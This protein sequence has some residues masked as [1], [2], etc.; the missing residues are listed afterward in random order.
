MAD[1]RYWWSLCD[2]LGDQGR[3]VS[4]YSLESP[5][6]WARPVQFQPSR[7]H[8]RRC[9]D[10]LS[11]QSSLC[12]PPLRSLQP[13]TT[14][15]M[16][17]VLL[18]HRTP[19]IRY[20]PDGTASRTERHKLEPKRTDTTEPKCIQD[21]PRPFLQS[22]YQRLHFASCGL[23]FRIKLGVISDQSLS[24]LTPTLS[25]PGKQPGCAVA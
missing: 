20:Q 15:S 7:P 9:R 11:L 5:V 12:C 16:P 19:L 1:P 18:H 21:L 25:H 8:R 10:P 4:I 6:W 24:R 14:P 17:P 2:R 23:D 13:S 3:E 22:R